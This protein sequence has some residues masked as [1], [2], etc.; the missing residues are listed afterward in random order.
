[1][2]I[3]ISS[4]V[5][6][7]YPVNELRTSGYKNTKINYIPEHIILRNVKELFI[8]DTALDQ[9]I[10][11]RINFCCKILFEYAKALIPIRELNLPFEKY[12]YG[13]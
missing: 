13:M 9:S 1:M 6:G 12:P 3:S 10:S 8:N 4:G 2:I 7:A 5:G 11:E